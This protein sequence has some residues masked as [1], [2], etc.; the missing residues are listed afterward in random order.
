MNIP[1]PAIVDRDGQFESHKLER[2][3]AEPSGERPGWSLYFEEG[4]GIWCPGDLCTQDPVPGETARLY[5][6]GFGYQV[7]G[8]VIDGRIYRYQTEDEMDA[9]HAAFVAEEHAKRQVALEREMPDRDRRRAALP[10]PFRL[11]LDGF[12]QA[13]PD[14][15]RDR[16]VY[17]LFCCE[18]AALIAGHFANKGAD[19]GE[20][21]GLLHAFRTASTEDEKAEL[22][23]LKYDEHS[24]NT[25]GC[26]NCLA[27]I[28]L[29][30][31]DLVPQMHASICPIVGCETCGCFASR[32]EAKTVAAAIALEARNEFLAALFPEVKG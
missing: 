9:E 6:Q 12:E 27:E 2:V 1:D 17:E 30:N 32:P 23:G 19:L 14:W 10:E 3:T 24:G 16:E 25:W 13:R 29:A 7:R 20:R 15:R 22:P 18:E 26:A 8:I 5:G 31:P 4:M 28:Y 21:L 11:R